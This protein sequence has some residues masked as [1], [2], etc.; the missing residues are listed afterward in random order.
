MKPYISMDLDDVVIKSGMEHFIEHVTVHCGASFDRE[1]FAKTHSWE[2]AMGLSAKEIYALTSSM[3][4]QHPLEFTAGAISA[5]RIIAKEACVI[6]N[7]ARHGNPLVAAIELIEH[8]EIPHY[9]IFGGM[10][11]KKHEPIRSVNAMLHLEDSIQEISCIIEHCPDVQIIQFPSD[12]SGSASML[13]EH[14]RV[15]V[16]RSVVGDYRTSDERWEKSWEEVL[17]RFL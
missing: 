2:E 14:P 12:F 6:F 17:E 4:H 8:S 5:L 1:V 9:G 10:Y 7:T 11:R 16:L 3:Q 15:H 13:L